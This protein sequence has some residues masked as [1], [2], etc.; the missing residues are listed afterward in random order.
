MK[1]FHQPP[2]LRRRT[3]EILE[4]TA[5]GGKLKR[6]VDIF[7]ITLILLNVVFIIVESIEDFLD[8]LG[9]FFMA[10]EIFS[11]VVFTMEYV[12]RSWVCVERE[13]PGSMLTRRLRYAVTPMALCD[14]LAILPSYLWL[15][16]GMDLRFFRT[17]RLMRIFK[18]TRYSS[19]ITLLFNV[20]RNEAA[21]FGAAVFIL[22]IVMILA[23][24]GMYFVEYEAQPQA[25][26][27]IPA[28]MWWAVAALTTVGYGDV[29]PIT[30]LGKFF[31]ACVT[32]VGIG[33]IALPSGI[34]ASGFSEQLRRRRN[35]YKQHVHE[36]L[37]NG[38]ITEEE[39][40]ALRQLRQNLGFT[41][42][43]ANEILQ[44]AARRAFTRAL[45]R[46]PHCGKPLPDSAAK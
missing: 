20:F 19:A 36:A 32:V 1:E 46:C 37:D 14:L 21:S 43:E 45:S 24:S 17:L 38:L 15:F 5:T 6:T 26:G 22:L 16:F 28:A 30:P 3:Y 7:L 11:M 18:L 10:F 12:A 13:Q 9:P 31:G 8:F 34:L 44:Q 39:K 33:M 4:T 23:S 35:T 40:I 41:E 42:E 29:T 25:F 2:T 27:S